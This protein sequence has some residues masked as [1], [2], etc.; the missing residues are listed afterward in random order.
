[1][2]LRICGTT[3]STKMRT[4]TVKLRLDVLEV[5]AGPVRPAR[6]RPDLGARCV[7]SQQALTAV[8]S[9]L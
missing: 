6:V 4:G 8:F 1:M 7:A 2:N 9:T 5:E 3:I